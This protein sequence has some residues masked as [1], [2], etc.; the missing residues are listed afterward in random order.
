MKAIKHALD[1]WPTEH[2]G[3]SPAELMPQALE[4]AGD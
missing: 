3:L 2:K 1:A 4:A